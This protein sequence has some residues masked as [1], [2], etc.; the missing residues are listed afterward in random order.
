VRSDAAGLSMMRM[1]SIQKVG[2]SGPDRSFTISLKKTVNDRSGPDFP[3]L[4]LLL[5]LDLIQQLLDPNFLLEGVVIVE[6]QLWNSTR[7]CSRCPSER[8]A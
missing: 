5:R 7:W 8:R 2:K 4:L 1:P 6:G 3:S